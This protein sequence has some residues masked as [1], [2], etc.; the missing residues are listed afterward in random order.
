MGGILAAHPGCHR[1]AWTNLRRPR[2]VRVTTR[3]YGRRPDEAAVDH[4]GAHRGRCPDGRE[5]GR[6]RQHP[7]LDS[8]EGQAISAN[9]VQLD[10]AQTWDAPPMAS[11]QLA[12]TVPAA[13]PRPTT[14]ATTTTVA[15]AVAASGDVDAPPVVTDHEETDPGG[16]STVSGARRSRC[17]DSDGRDGTAG[18]DAERR[19]AGDWDTS[20]PVPG[21][22]HAHAR[23]LG[24]DDDV[25]T[26]T[27][28]A[29][30][31]EHGGRTTSRPSPPSSTTTPHPT[32]TA[33]RLSRRSVAE[34]GDG[35]GDG[36]GAAGVGD[37]EVLDHPAV[38][39]DHA[40]TLGLGRRE[41]LDHARASTR[42]RRSSATTPRWP[43]RPGRGGS[44]SCRRSPSATPWSALGGEA[45]VVAR[46]RCRRRRGST[47]PASRAASTAVARYG[48]RL[49]R[50]GISGAPISRA[51]SLV[52]ITSTATRGWAAMART[53]K[54][55][56]GVSIIAQIGVSV[57]PA[58]SRRG[59]HDVD[60]GPAADLG[61]HDGRRAAPRRRRRC[62][63]RPTAWPG[64]CSGSSARGGRTRP[65]RRRPPPLAGGRLGVGRDGVLEVEDDRVARD[66]LGLLERL[67]RSTTACRAPT[68]GAAA[69]RS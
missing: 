47:L 64:R 22:D 68:G 2:H 30:D 21:D 16:R 38:D 48:V 43:A 57:P 53:S 40:A 29:V 7:V 8:S 14:T 51:R 52:P 60:L 67:G 27:A 54:I 62:R 10:E 42:P 12:T 35:V 46:R 39:G 18:D 26:A 33:R 50:P 31:L 6:P 34:V 24:P 56:V 63:R 66:R 65:S 19:R 11:P 17:D 23:Q 55:A 3:S 58:A 49:L 5:R 41:R 28:P 1:S 15:S 4:L 44:A 61:D 37:V 32:A 25:R 20:A 59:G 13:E 9:R 69:R 45:L 36:E